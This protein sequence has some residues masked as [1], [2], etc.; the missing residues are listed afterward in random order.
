M[1]CV[2][3]SVTMVIGDHLF[4]WYDRKYNKKMK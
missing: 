1:V 4:V 3:K 2:K